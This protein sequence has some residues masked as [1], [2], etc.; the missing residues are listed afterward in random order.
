MSNTATVSTRNEITSIKTD[1]K[2][3]SAKAPAKLILTGEHAVVYGCPSIAMAIDLYAVSNVTR[4]THNLLGFDFANLK[5][6][7]KHTL[8]TLGKLKEKAF[9]D[10][11]R[12]LRGECSIREV[13]NKPFEL[14]QLAVSHFLDNLNI[15]LPGGIDIQTNSDIPAG[16]G[17]GSSAATIMSLLYAVGNLLDLEL[18]KARYI[19]LGK[20]TENLQHGK[21]SGVDIML[22]VEGGCHKFYNSNI[23]ALSINTQNMYIVNTGRPIVT[24]GECVSGVKKHFKNNDSLLQEFE[25]ITLLLEELL[26]ANS[27]SNVNS[28]KQDA[29]IHVIKENHKLLNHIGVVP[30]RVQD[31]INEVQKINAAAKVCGSGSIAGDNAGAVLVVCKNKENYFLLRELTTKYG[32]TVQPINLDSNGIQIIQQQ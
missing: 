19:E 9:I 20:T 30:Q 13:V 24:T 32:Y 28:N 22:T 11:H 21:S 2:T 8:K 31:F 7:A 12:F 6:N 14:L 18:N 15:A 3:V 17:M 16:C 27:S 26:A 4:N 10:Y 29:F 25:N 5:Y 23:T 1:I